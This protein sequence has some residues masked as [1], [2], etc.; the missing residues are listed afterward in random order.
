MSPVIK[1]LTLPFR[2]VALVFALCGVVLLYIVGLGR[3]YLKTILSNIITDFLFSSFNLDTERQK[4]THILGATG[5]GKSSAI[6]FFLDENIRKQ[7][8]FLLIEPHGELVRRVLANK[9]FTQPQTSKKLILL[10]FDRNPPAL[11]IFALPLPENNAQQFINGLASDITAAFAANMQPAMTEAQFIMLR[12]LFIAG[13]YMQKATFLDV[14]DMLTDN[15]KISLDRL[16]TPPLQNYFQQDFISGEAKRTRTALRGRLNSFVIPKQMYE[17]LCAKTCDVDFRAIL[18]EGKYVIIK[19]TT[20]TLGTFEAVTIGNLI[21][22]IF[23]KYAFERLNQTDEK[24]PFFVYFDE[25]QYYMSETVERCLTGARKTGVSYTLA[26]HEIGQTGMTSAAQRT[27]INNCNVKIYGSL[28]WKDMKEGADILGLEDRSLLS[29][30]K[31]GQFF[32]KAGR[33]DV[34]L[35]HFPVRFSI[36]KAGFG[37]GWFINAYAKPHETETMLERIIK[38]PPPPMYEKTIDQSISTKSKSFNFNPHGDMPFS[39]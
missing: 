9:R 2:M 38:K 16:P 23:S 11:N 10:D 29:K 6:E 27:I 8:G 35:K 21:H 4:H 31:A 14:L 17:S 39:S 25:A 24:K 32:I 33:N 7:Q 26:H 15:S 37:C 3:C 5:A 20:T 36:K 18:S 30:L 1:I 34:F 13:F 28:K 12:N 22:S 19:A